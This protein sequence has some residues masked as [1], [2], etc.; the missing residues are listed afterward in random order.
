[1]S[2]INEAF[3]GLES[4]KARYRVGWITDFPVKH[5]TIIVPTPL[6]ERLEHRSGEALACPL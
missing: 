5:R 6:F 3:A 2:N 4:G 1:M